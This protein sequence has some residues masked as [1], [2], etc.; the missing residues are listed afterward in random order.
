MSKR[1]IDNVFVGVEHWLQE[2]PCK[3]ELRTKSETNLEL[4]E[5]MGKNPHAAECKLLQ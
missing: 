2:V 3:L 5:R 4:N 1:E